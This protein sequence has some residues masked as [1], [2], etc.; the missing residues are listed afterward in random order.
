M[1]ISYAV[2]TDSAGNVYVTGTSMRTSELN[3]LDM[4][5]IK[6]NSF[7]IEKWVQRYNGPGNRTD[8]AWAIGVDKFGNVF[9]QWRRFR[10]LT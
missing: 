10:N 1:D 3:S 9:C 7:G 4:A 8:Y 6:Y 2:D 5:T